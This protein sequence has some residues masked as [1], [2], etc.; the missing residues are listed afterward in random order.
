[1]DTLQAIFARRSI[2]KYKDAPIPDEHLN[3]ILE[4]ARQ[5]PSAGNRQPWHFIVV[6][7]PEQRRRVANACN[8]QM[9]MADAA[10]I[11]VALGLPQVSPKWYPVDVAIAV[12]NLVLAARSLGYGTCWVGAF[13]PAELKRV[14]GIPDEAEV[15]ICTPLGVPDA[16]SPARLRKDWNEVFSMGGKWRAE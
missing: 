15:V 14:C 7:D 5:A 2:R 4:A 1:M 12:E 6:R 3:Q 10:C 11:I 9:W 8:S 13:D 16:D